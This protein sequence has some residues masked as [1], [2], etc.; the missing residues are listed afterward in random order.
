MIVALAGAAPG[1]RAGVAWLVGAVPGAG[2]LRDGQK[3][4]MPYA[5]VL[6]LGLALGA[7]A[8]ANR[9]ANRLAEPAGQLVLVAVAALPVVVMPDLARGAAGM[10][11]PVSYPTDWDKV[12]AVV[13]ADPGDVLSLP[14]AEY[15][16]YRWNG[17][18]T[19]I[20]PAPRYLPAAAVTDDTLYVSAMTVDGENSRAAAVRQVLERGGSAAEAGTHWVLLDRSARQST[21]RSAL[22]GLVATYV[23]P[24]LKLYAN[25]TARE[26][27]GT[28][29]VRRIVVSAAHGV[30]AV[31]VFGAV[32]LL[33]RKPT[34][35]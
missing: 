20:D 6:A 5:L 2:I 28:V 12:A 9:L 35:W 4:L 23:G 33:R 30:A 25:P 1:V 11:R 18:Q 10:L 32:W 22:A 31:L 15:R 7:Q 13:A 3:F 19:V 24:D 14:F 8:L 21:P 26:P 17:G 29:T 16:S 27:N 34:P